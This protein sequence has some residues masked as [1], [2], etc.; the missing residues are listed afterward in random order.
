MSKGMYSDEDLKN[1][2]CNPVVV[3]DV[4]CKNEYSNFSLS[5]E[6]LELANQTIIRRTNYSVGSRL[7]DNAV[8]NT[9]GTIVAAKYLNLNVKEC[10][11]QGK[12]FSVNDHQVD[13]QTTTYDNGDIFLQYRCLEE[14][15]DVSILTRNKGDI[16]I[17][18]GWIDYQRFKIKNK[19]RNL[20]EDNMLSVSIDQLEPMSTLPAYLSKPKYS[21]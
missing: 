20:R 12:G 9:K 2:I 8:Q 14:F 6:E 21:D 1:D 7:Y 17:Q 10:L 11:K 15:K 3:K 13:I 18:L 4:E 16:F 5:E 19:I